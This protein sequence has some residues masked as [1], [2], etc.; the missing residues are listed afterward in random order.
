ML[1]K[2]DD[3]DKRYRTGGVEVRALNR[4]SLE[5]EHGDY[6]ALEG[7][8]GC[9]KSTLL[10]VL[11]MLESPTSGEYHFDGMPVCGLSRS[12]Q[13]ALRNRKIAFVFQNFN[14]IAELSVADNIELP[15]IYREMRVRERRR[16]VHEV[17]ERLALAHRASLKPRHLSGGEQ[18]RVAIARALAGNPLLLLADEPTGNL[19]SQ[20]S[21]AVMDLFSQLHAEGS[22]IFIV[23]H[24]P[25]IARKASRRLTMLDGAIEEQYRDDRRSPR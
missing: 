12:A 14:L 22:T 16:R 17:L 21:Q 10:S 4:I 18:Q 5:I 11:G 20:H 8:S 2:L 1:V 9:G 15:L 7:P 3:V 6:L 25:D 19:D 23:T 24:N 13:A